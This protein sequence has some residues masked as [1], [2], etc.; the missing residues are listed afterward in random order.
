MESDGRGTGAVHFPSY[1]GVPVIG[2]ARRLL[3]VI[4]ASSA[5]TALAVLAAPV[6]AQAGLLNLGSCDNATLS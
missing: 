4:T 1:S 3:G 2:T 5:L 6:S